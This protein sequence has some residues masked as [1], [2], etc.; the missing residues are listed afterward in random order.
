MLSQENVMNYCCL[1][2]ADK[3]KGYRLPAMSGVPKTGASWK[4]ELYSDSA[5]STST[6]DANMNY[7]MKEKYTTASTTLAEG[8]CFAKD[9]IVNGGSPFKFAGC[10]STAATFTATGISYILEMFIDDN[11]NF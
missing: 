1:T 7:Y 11:C 2:G 5:C 6:T 3:I 10:N 8:T 4:Q 9:S